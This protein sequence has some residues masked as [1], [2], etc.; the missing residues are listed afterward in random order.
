MDKF[1]NKK[2]H[3]PNSSYWVYQLHWSVVIWVHTYP[4]LN[5][6]IVFQLKT[7]T[8][9]GRAESGGKVG[10]VRS[11]RQSVRGD[12]TMNK[13]PSTVSVPGKN[14]IGYTWEYAKTPD[15]RTKWE[16]VKT[17]IWNPD[18]HQFL[19]RTGKSWGQ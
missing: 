14:G 17:T 15:N 12:S 7:A 5:I 11:S 4:V 3:F 8:V 6:E 10:G 18:T 13:T 2:R 16:K 1:K 19:G 9:V